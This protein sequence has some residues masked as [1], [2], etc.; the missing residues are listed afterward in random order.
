[1]PK[2]IIDS[3][4]LEFKPGQ[5][6]IEVA[7]EN[8]IDI[9]HFCWHPELSV[10]GNC[11]VCLVDVEKMP[12]LMI[13]CST[14]AADGMVVHT[15]TE[16]VVAARNAVM[17]F[18]LINHP[19][20]CPICDEAGECKLQDYTYKYSK[21]ESRF[22]ENKNLKQKH[23]S[24]GPNVMFDGE[25]C[26]SCS[27][28]IRFCDEI[29]KD[30][31]LT[32][33]QRGDRVT[34]TTF[35]GEELDNPYS[36][37]TIDICPVGALTSKDFRFRSRVWDMSATKSIC[38]G[39]AKGCNVDIWVRNNEI[40]R[41]TPRFNET[42]NSFW[43]CD[44]GRLN[45]FKDVNAADRID[46]PKIRR[47]GQLETI[48]WDEIFAEI[49]SRIKSFGKNEIAFLGSAY[50]TCED[51]YM[52]VKFAKSI[53]N[54]NNIDFVRHNN[55]EFGDELLRQ[56]DV[57]PNVLGAELTG[58]QP[59]GSGLNYDGIVKGIREGKIKALYVMEDDIVNIDPQLENIFA[60]LDLLIVHSSNFNKTTDLADIIMP[61]STVA[62][63]HGTFVN[64][65]GV[66][67]RIRPAVV[68][69]DADRT[70]DGMEMS[71]LDK[72][73]TKFD[74]WMNGIIRDARPSWK[75]LASL[76]G[77]MGNKMKYKMSD[78]VFV[79]MSNSIKA[80]KNITYDEIG[81]SGVKLSEQYIK[82]MVND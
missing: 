77:I 12:K 6:V 48:G 13:A 25:R 19:L 52:L 51:N 20:D 26:I 23:V 4:E 46:S 69:I 64:T 2:L 45:A 27:R 67:Q 82:Q 54:C 22:V 14:V 78:E 70:L 38:P 71:R 33:I 43:M 7:R 11:R 17:E 32:F 72:F 79:E 36:M 57:T 56:D 75:V 24:I 73:G 31:Q 61:A 49:S 37:N 66:L 62:E 5:T 40:M 9:P 58:V 3:K 18:I 50:A 65:D 42:V 8:G 81:E 60:K 59:P 1:M 74:R 28:C 68:T 63:K 47:E 29:A 30:N 10:S 34:I 53:I 55:P 35:P 39:C 15:Q 21:G 44:E 76:A 16:K 41:I 80:F